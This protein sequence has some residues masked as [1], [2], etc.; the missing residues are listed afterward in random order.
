MS[1]S[2][3]TQLEGLE[4][5][6]S[7]ESVGQNVIGIA[8]RSRTAEFCPHAR[9]S[10]RHV[11]SS[12]GGIV[13]LKSLERSIFCGHIKHWSISFIPE[14]IF[15]MLQLSASHRTVMHPRPAFSDRILQCAFADSAI[16]WGMQLGSRHRKTPNYP[17]IGIR[18]HERIPSFCQFL[19]KLKQSMPK[20]QHQQ[21]G[22][23]KPGLYCLLSQLLIGWVIYGNISKS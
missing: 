4:I 17:L 12:K 20:K 23:K 5:L 9:K 16:P 2:R 8:T 10:R 13:K 11:Q 7:K 15:N 19:S 22:Y 1:G 14:H 6:L 18:S 3:F 21:L